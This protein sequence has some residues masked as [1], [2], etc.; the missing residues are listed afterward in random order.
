MALDPEA[1]DRALAFDASRLKLLRHD[2]QALIDLVVWAPL[3]SDRL[4]ALPRIRKRALNIGERVAA[5][6]ASR[7]WIPHS[8]ERAKNAIASA[9]AALQALEQFEWALAELKQGTDRDAL[10]L[11][12]AALRAAAEQPIREYGNHCAR[13]LETVTREEN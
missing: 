11:A 5:L 9:L 1:L 12:F 7:T 4:G 2:W 13:L 3:D 10:T 6:G 8:R